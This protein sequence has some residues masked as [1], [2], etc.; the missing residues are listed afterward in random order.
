MPSDYERIAEAI[1]FIERQAAAQPALGDIAAHVGL[2]PTHL[3]RVFKRWAGV[4]PKRFLQ[5]LTVE[6]AKMLLDESESVLDAAFAV[7][8]S[9]PGRLHDLF[10]GVEAVTPGEYKRAGGGLTIRWG[11]HDTPYGLALI[12]LTE[13]GICELWFTDEHPSLAVTAM[14]EAWEG[15][16]L[17]EDTTATGPVIERIFG[18]SGGQA[19]P[20]EI[21][22]HLKG[23]N[24]Q[25][26]VWKA[27]LH[28]P[29]GALISYSDLARRMGR[30]TSARAVANAVGANPI[31]YVIPCHRVLRSTGDIG[32]YA[33]GIERKR[34]MLVREAVG[35]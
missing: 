33:G 1:R 27:L 13:R 2:S 28:V 29:E 30:P 22:L 6:H 11:V 32:G 23:T 25:L 17:V 3:Q 35:R 31:G 7:G 26:Q 20:G 19:P 4:S 5:Y 16:E 14:G 12:G 15:A 8:L 10:V 18:D 9:G 21:M 34:A 24:F